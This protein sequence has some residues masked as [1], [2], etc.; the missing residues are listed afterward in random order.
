MHALGAWDTHGMLLLGMAVQHGC[1][2]HTHP[3]L[4]AH[5][6]TQILATD[7]PNTCKLAY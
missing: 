6:R 5:C 4:I 7:I 2:M 3:S 1:S